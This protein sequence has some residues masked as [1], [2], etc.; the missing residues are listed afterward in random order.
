MSGAGRVRAGGGMGIRE[1]E[2]WDTGLV[3]LLPLRVLEMTGDGD[4]NDP[5]S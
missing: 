4:E 5:G 3:Y 2:G 1:L